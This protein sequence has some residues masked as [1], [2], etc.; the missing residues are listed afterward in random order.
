MLSNTKTSQKNS[1][2]EKRQL[3]QRK[4]TKTKRQMPQREGEKRQLPQRKREQSVTQTTHL[5]VSINCRQMPQRLHEHHTTSNVEAWDKYIHKQC[6]SI[7][8]SANAATFARTSSH[9]IPSPGI[10]LILNT[11]NS[12]LIMNLMSH[13]HLT[14]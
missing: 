3:L 6:L 7:N 11:E 14:A 9:A 10:N 1:E 4:R 13:W 8:C 2:G 5:L 12:E